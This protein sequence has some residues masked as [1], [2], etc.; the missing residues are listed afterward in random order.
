MMNLSS[1][2]SLCGCGEAVNQ[3]S[4]PLFFTAHGQAQQLRAA[5]IELTVKL[6]GEAHASV[7]LNVLFGSKE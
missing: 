5:V 3:T 2:V 1:L 4:L 6:P 7:G